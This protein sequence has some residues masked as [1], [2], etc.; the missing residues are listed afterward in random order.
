MKQFIKK[1]GRTIKLIITVICVISGCLFSSGIQFTKAA[2][3]PETVEFNDGGTSSPTGAYYIFKYKLERKSYDRIKGTAEYELT[4]SFVIQYSGIPI[5]SDVVYLNGVEKGTFSSYNSSYVYPGSYTRSEKI[6]LTLKE[7]DNKIKIVGQYSGND[8]GDAQYMI[9]IDKFGHDPVVHGINGTW[10]AG[11]VTSGKRTWQSL[12]T[13]GATGSAEGNKQATST[14]FF[15]SDEDEHPQRVAAYVSSVPLSNNASIKGIEKQNANGTWTSIALNWDEMDNAGV[16]RLKACTKDQAGNEACGTRT[17]TVQQK[18]YQVKY[19]GNNATGGT[20]SNSSHTYDVSKNLTAIAYTKTG[21]RFSHWNTKADGTGTSYTN[22]KS[23]KNLT[24]THGATVN[25]YA[26]W[27]PNTYTVKY[28]GNNATGGTMS[29]SSHTYDVSKALNKNAYIR[30]GW[31]FM[32]WNAKADGSGTTYTDQQSVMN[33]T[34]THEATVNLYAQW[35]KAPSLVT[36]NKVFYENELTLQEWKSNYRMKNI[37]ADDLEDGDI[38]D[39]IKIIADYVDVNKPGSYLVIYEVT[40]SV[41]QTVQKNATV[42]IKYNNPP[43]VHA[44]NQ[45][46]RL[47]SITQKQ[48]DE[49]LRYQLATAD[50]IEDG[51]ISDNIKITL[52]ETDV[53]V[54]GIYRVKYE[55]TDRF[56]KKSDKL[57]TVEIRYNQ[58]P[59]IE[60]DNIT[61][62]ENEI[63]N[64]VLTEHLKQQA[65]AYD[66]EDGN[67]SDQIRIISNNA[68]TRTPG[69]YEVTYEVVDSK[70]A[71]GTK[72]IDVTV[73]ENYQPILQLFVSN[74]RFIEG[75]YTQSEWEEQLRMKGV[76]A[77]DKEDHDLT[78]QI[79]II[80][81][82]TDPSKRGS[83]K[84]VYTVTDRFGKSET[85][86]AKVTVEPNEAPIIY[87]N[88]KYFTTADTITDKLLLKNVYA[89][90]DHDIDIDKH[91]TIQS[92]TIINGKA[93]T[94][95]VTYEAIDSLGKKGTKTIQV[96]ITEALEP[97]ITPPLPE[98]VEALYLWNGHEHGLV[99]ITKL[100]EP[101]IIGHDKEALKDVVFGIYAKEDIIYQNRIVLQSGSLVAITKVDAQ[102]QLNAVIHHEGKYVLKELQTNDHYLL[103]EKEYEFEYK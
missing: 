74:K 94:Y 40:D 57:I 22:Q 86:T 82:T 4:Q 90:D 68:D 73:L 11:E 37:S 21:Y 66:V 75:Q 59:Q 97:P 18:K 103:D 58:A 100:M 83:Y 69:I 45:V 10:T 61:I 20:M 51:D 95:E 43:T 101:S 14:G 19:N 24:S 15:F 85:K 78:D 71:V 16:Y 48:W 9:H 54:P 5:Y 34:S 70:G 25:L 62:Y 84:V 33:L 38:T 77:H 8:S 29:N 65:T 56:G 7:G 27:V 64:A 26:Q 36:T 28:N 72:T 88:D 23:V 49:E 50:D 87:A 31:K 93:G 76:T 89:S 96:H 13:D 44:E 60:A 35:N 53:T 99:N 42:T 91:I 47:G 32:G 1:N 81:D 55:A 67:L 80:S 63:S 46:Y 39:D 3:P 52:D 41:D 79:Q 12:W 92:N 6:L 17:V 30:S 98:D 102:G 2:E